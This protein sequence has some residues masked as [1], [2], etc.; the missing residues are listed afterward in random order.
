MIGNVPF[1]RR[2]LPVLSAFALVA[3]CSIV[4]APAQVGRF[5]LTGQGSVN[6][7]WLGA[8]RGL[9]VIDTQRSLTDARGAVTELRRAGQPIVAI[10]VTHPHPDHV[11]GLGVLHEAFPDAPIYA[12]RSTI[13]HIRTDPLG[14]YDRTRSQPGSDYAA[15]LTVPDQVVAPNATVE[16]G[17]TTV[18][19]AEFG[20]GESATSTVYY[21][22][23]SRALFAGDLVANRATPDLLE[24]HSC[25]WLTQLDRLQERF[26][27]ARFLYPGHGKLGDATELIDAQR[28]YLRQF[29][30]LVGA[31]IA[32]DSPSGAEVGHV[33]I[34]DL[35]EELG[36]RYPDYPSATTLP[37]LAE[38]NVIAVAK[39]LAA[40]DPAGLPAA[41]RG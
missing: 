36:K 15:E 14:F 16:A 19:S 26:P 5:A 33:E 20:E 40:E 18:Q 17:G 21:E 2:L 8:K 10:L 31:A 13:D 39:E 7:F 35:L 12:S 23:R 38:E 24:G 3:G 9:I 6:T 11:G 41:C 27:D 22:P 37:T 30:R 1:R 32:A 25:S 34:Q 4:P 28:D 29:R